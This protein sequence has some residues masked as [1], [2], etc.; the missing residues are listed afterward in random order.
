M[1]EFNGLS[2]KLLTKYGVKYTICSKLGDKKKKNQKLEN[3]M[4]KYVREPLYY[5]Q[6]TVV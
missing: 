5:S 3:L 4:V 2:I 1:I 6:Q